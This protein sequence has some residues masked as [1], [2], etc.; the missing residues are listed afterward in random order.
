MFRR[1][2]CVDRVHRGSTIVAR[3]LRGYRRVGSPLLY[4]KACADDLASESAT[5]GGQSGFVHPRH[6][7]DC[8]H[9]LYRPS[10]LVRC[11]RPSTAP[12]G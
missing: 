5:R 4:V 8:K 9:G 2:V 1:T 6:Q 3:R 12:Q 10:F 11:G 7:C